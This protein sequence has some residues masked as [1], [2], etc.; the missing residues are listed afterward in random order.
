M[1]AQNPAESNSHNARDLRM[2]NHRL[3][4]QNEKLTQA[5]KASRE[6]LA[7]INA[8]L[9]DMAEPP[10]TYGTLLEVNASA[11]TA[12]VFTSNRH[13][14][15]A[16]SPLI[17]RMDLQPGATVRLGENLQVVEVTGFADSGDVATVVEVVGDRLIIADKMGEESIVKAA[18]PL[19]TLMTNREL[20]T[21]DSVV[22][23]RR[24]GWAF[25]M[26]P[27]EEVSSL[28]LEEVPDVSYSDIGGLSRQIEQIRDAV[29]LPFLH[30]E[31]YRHYGLRPPKGVLLY[32]PPGN[33]KTLI[34]K[35]VANSL[36]Q[37]MGT[38]KQGS[39]RYAD[40][41]FLNVKGPELLNKFVGET[42]RQIRQIFERARKIAHAGKPV[43]VFFDEMEAIFR[44]RGTGVSSDMESTVVPQLLSELDGVEG[45]DNVIVIGASNREELIDP[46][47]LR[48]GRLDVKIRVDRPDEDGA[49]DILSKHID[50][51]LPLDADLVA[52][53]GGTE[54]AAAALCR[55]IVEELFRRDAE[56]RFVTLHLADGTTKD[57]YWAD[58]VSG[59]MLA[60]IVDRA[61]TYAIKRALSASGDTPAG[62]AATGGLTAADVLDAI[63]AEINDS[64]N[65]PDTTNPTEWARISGHASGRVVDITLAD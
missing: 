4:S 18:R 29:E 40:S 14:R 59:A 17:D 53:H 65:L 21:G 64:E 19:R 60:N 47:I 49:L 6:K 8:R 61:K 26:I 1:T 23:D 50:S 55:T 27:R 39:S 43:I 9:A 32:G 56:H 37:S 15:L 63:T 25:D 20:T 35:A 45:L 30:P 42:E 62:P 33:G 52:E 46:A 34:A 3:G 24:S 38:G 11:K 28:V 2:A 54:A 51:S 12:E 48:P 13:M 31:I 7:E 22:V 41:Y 5:L 58:F 10:S 44:T 57:L 16:V 36:S